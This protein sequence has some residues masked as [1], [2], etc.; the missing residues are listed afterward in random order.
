M[1][2]KRVESADQA[3]ADIPDGATLLVSGFG[4]PGQP[5]EL[6]EALIRQG[7]SDLTI[8]NNNAAAGGDAIRHLFEAER[9][10]KVI[11]SF[12]RAFDST[13]FEDLYL[14]GKLELE[15]VPQGTLAE[16]IRAA[17]A[18]VGA[19]FTQTGFG[20]ELAEGKETRTIDGRN[21]VLEHPIR[22]DFALVK[23]YRSDPW[24][25]LVYRKTS[26]NF[27]PIMAAAAET[28]IA[29]SNEIVA[30]GALDPEV[31]VTPSIY[32]DRLVE[33]GH[34]TAKETAA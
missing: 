10:R 11:C 14:A 6:I 28:T 8:V 15:L 33:V 19:F 5:V 12:P 27:G 34:P 1:I 3:V 31:I 4:P 20:T 29:E 7:A 17:G 23:A 26:R 16:R 2:D 30:L 21:Y 25:N 9:V 13:V 22:G 32:I 24:G 18:G